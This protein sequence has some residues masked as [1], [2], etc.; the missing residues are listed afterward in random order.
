VSRRGWALFVAMGVIW[1][2][3]YLLIKVADGGVSV[4]VLVFTRVA[5]GALLL[6]PVALHR[7]ELGALR[8]HWPWLVAFAAFEIVGPFALL[9]SAEKHLASSTTGLLVAAVPIFGAVLAQLTG[10][11]DRLTPVRWAGL[12][13]GFG[14]VAV[15]AGPD[16]ASGDALSVFEVLLTALG[17]AIGP[18]IANRKLA[19]V[20][21]AAVN[22]VCLGM[23]ALVYAVPA[24]L[25][26]PHTVPSAKVIASLSALG[27]I[28]TATAFIVFF[29]L[30][31]EVG[32]ARATVIT[33][34]NPAVAVAL[35][36]IVLGEQLTPA[37]GGAFVLILG[38]SV[39]ATRASAPRVTS[40]SEEESVPTAPS[41]AEI[42]PATSAALAAAVPEEP[43]AG[44]PRPDHRTGA[45]DPAC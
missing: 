45:T 18:L 41:N 27:A 10:G 5:L 34:V 29:A 11:Q 32:P 33:Y 30:I 37:I 8:G 24:A 28:C 17:Y 39:L 7:G 15:L 42:P 1:G 43:Q 36:V 14:G 19:G 13:I 26:L 16:A 40:R 38:G 25:T 22:T 6:L 44:G 12:I 9:S 20:P 31:A 21:P 35:G 2:I 4:P 23:T 3:P